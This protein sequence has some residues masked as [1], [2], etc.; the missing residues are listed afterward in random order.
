MF[1]NYIKTA[2]RSIWKNKTFSL[3]KVLSLAI[4]LSASFVIG[5]MVYHDFSFD[6]FHNDSDRIY[7]IISKF[8][9]PQATFHNRGVAQPLGPYLEE[10]NTGFEAV[11]SFSTQFFSKVDIAGE[12]RFFRNRQ[13]AILATPSYFQIFN[14]NWVLGSPSVLN[15]PNTVVLSK[16]T[17]E[18][19][20]PGA[21]MEAIIGKN[22]VYDSIPAKVVGIVAD[23]Q[24]ST[25]LY[26]KEFISKET[27]RN[28]HLK[29]R[30]L[31][32]NWDG[33]NSSTQLFVKVLPGYD[34]FK[35]NLKLQSIASEFASDDAIKREETRIFSLEPLG[36][37]HFNNT[38]GIFDYT[39][40]VADKEV[41]FGLS[42]TALFLLLLACINFINLN[43]AQAAQ[44][45]KEI[46]VRKTLGSSKKQ[47]M[48]QFMTET[49]LLT[50]AAAILSV[51]FSFWLLQIFS[52][53]L[54][55]GVDFS[56]FK[57][58]IVLLGASV[59]LI[60]ISFLSGFYPSLVLSNF[61]PVK[62]L[63]SQFEHQK[64]KPRLRQ[65]L[66]VF[67]FVIAQVFI[68]AMLIV[69]KQL[70][71][72]ISQDMGFKT[73][74][75]L[76]IRAWH[77]DDLTK[78][79]T[80]AKELSKIPEITQISLAGNPPAS[81][82]F[83]SMVVDYFKD[84][85]KISTVLQQLFGDS[86]YREVY[87]IQLLAGRDRLND[88]ISEFVINEA[89]M[90]E[91]GFKNPEDVLGEM[92]DVGDMKIPIVGVMKDFH[93]RS[94]KSTIDPMV[95][96]GDSYREFY[97]QFNTI[98]LSVNGNITDLSGTL[99][100]IETQWGLVYPEEPF[101]VNFMDDTVKQFYNKERK[102]STLL[103]WATGLSIAISCLGLLGLVVYTTERRTREIG[104]RKVLGASIAQL[105]VL[106]CKDFLKLV[107]IAFIIA[108]PL[109]WYSLHKWLE[110]FAFKTDLSWWIFIASG[111]LM[112]FIAFIIM[113][114]KTIAKAN[115]NP[116]KSLRT[117]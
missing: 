2:I 3:I 16:S 108:V 36:D 68:I 79:E 82:N 70:N 4:G 8:K 24:E 52:D 72:M 33:T 1:K 75:N 91:L 61:K 113:S 107:G 102:T 19:Y 78:R 28:T 17:A 41:L 88:T 100:K 35:I 54:Q 81:K 57:N 48:F 116:V 14:Y 104:I 71:Y 10:N 27:A 25:D 15:E 59:L 69:G 109:A 103:A 37:I 85:N 23:L 22:L 77:D 97:A 58:P 80:L 55:Q 13:Q 101:E 117:E 98:H 47:L 111:L 92:I 7:R 12:D 56:L 93:Q 49:A 114:I 38:N 112:C 20:F 95:L 40:Y 62:A 73:S 29:E 106:L 5:L 44:R 30:V 90:K 51:L 74:A 65:Y 32:D 87:G 94:L 50:L 39:D 64:D 21:S 9:S 115:T 60:L 45:G 83:N 31:S 18:T 11:S 99:D 96:V 42:L 110:N 86:N 89:Y 76:Y 53:F 63:K 6:T 67:Q 26:F 43:T 66:T 105:N 46:G 84:G 34:L